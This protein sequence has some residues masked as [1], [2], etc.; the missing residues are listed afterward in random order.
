AIP[1]RSLW[2]CGITGVKKYLRAW[3]FLSWLF[4]CIGEEGTYHKVSPIPILAPLQL[5]V[6]M[7]RRFTIAIHWGKHPR[8]RTK[9]VFTG[10]CIA[11]ALVLPSFSFAQQ[12]WE[13]QSRILAPDEEKATPSGKMA[14]QSARPAGRP[15]LVLQIGIPE[16]VTKVLFSP[17]GALLAA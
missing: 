15:Q 16:P 17:D 3:Q 1:G 10:W 7:I 9:S 13:R 4:A 5:E 12:S 14:G 2:P 8:V 6:H 11:L